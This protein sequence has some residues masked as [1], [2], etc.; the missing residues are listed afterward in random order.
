MQSLRLPL[1]RSAIA[2]AIVVAC[3][4]GTTAVVLLLWRPAPLHARAIQIVD[5]TYGGNCQ[6]A[7]NATR[8]SSRVKHGNATASLMQACENTDLLCPYIV[9]Q[10]LLGDPAAGCDKDFQASWRCGHEPALQRTEVEPEA[11]NKIAWLGCSGRP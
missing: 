7:S 8:N 6:A 5:A 3:F 10:L 2:V 4:L 11:K 9:D 1:G